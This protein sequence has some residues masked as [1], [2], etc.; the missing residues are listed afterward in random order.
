MVSIQASPPRVG[1]RGR[2]QAAATQQKFVLKSKIVNG[3][4]W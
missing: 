3:D 4:M 2:K 1:D